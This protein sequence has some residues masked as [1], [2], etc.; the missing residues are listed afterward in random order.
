M[1]Y[2]KYV[3]FR[4]INKSVESKEWELMAEL[5]LKPQD[6]LTQS[7]TISV[8]PCIPLLKFAYKTQ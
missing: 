4:T 7:H 6:I 1:F 5:G 2:F 3:E 8:R